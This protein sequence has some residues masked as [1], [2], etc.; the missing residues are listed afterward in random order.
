ME[1]SCSP[2]TAHQPTVVITV[3][4]LATSC[5]AREWREFAVVFV[6]TELFYAIIGF[7]R[8]R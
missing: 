3:S 7:A 2:E 5:A 8:R 4:A 6:G 1:A